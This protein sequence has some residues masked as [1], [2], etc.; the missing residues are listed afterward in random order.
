[1][2]ARLVAPVRWRWFA[3]GGVANQHAHFLDGCEGGSLTQLRIVQTSQFPHR[4]MRFDCA[5]AQPL[6][7]VSVAP[8]HRFL[9]PRALTHSP[10]AAPLHSFLARNDR[11]ALTRSLCFVL[12]SPHRTD[13]C[14]GSPQVGG[15]SSAGWCPTSSKPYRAVPCRWL[16]SSS[17]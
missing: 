6:L 14:S 3:A 17:L 8:S 4:L 5:H 13:T 10:S 11:R 12:S 9:L 1:M 7:C 2:R 16:R 15:H